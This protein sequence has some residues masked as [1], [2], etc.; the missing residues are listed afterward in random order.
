MPYLPNII[1]D[2]SFDE[3]MSTLEC[4][5]L[6]EQLMRIFNLNKFGIGSQDDN[7]NLNLFNLHVTNLQSSK[8]TSGFLGS[9]FGPDKRH[10]YPNVHFHEPPFTE[11]FPDRR[12]IYMSPHAKETMTEY[13]HEAFYIIGGIVDRREI[14][15]L[16]PA[17]CSQLGIRSVR[18]PI[19]LFVHQEVQTLCDVYKL[20]HEFKYNPSALFA[21]ESI[22]KLVKRHIPHKKPRQNA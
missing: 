13:D 11:I 22:S 15:E 9:L 2:I 8:L 7:T 10:Y 12:L 20:L 21:Q 16:T 1:F 17:K 14:I 6:A 4:K 5:N 18:L 19:E 3:H